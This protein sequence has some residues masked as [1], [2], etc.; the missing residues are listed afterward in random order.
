MDVEFQFYKIKG[1][2][3]MDCGDGCATLGMCL[4]PQYFFSFASGWNVDVIKDPEA[5]I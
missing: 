3:E 1:V 2:M 5:A 4:I